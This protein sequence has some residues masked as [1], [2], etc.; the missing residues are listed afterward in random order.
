MI[1]YLI[2]M[3]TDVLHQDDADHVCRLISKNTVRRSSR[4][5]FVSN[6]FVILFNDD[7][8]ICIVKYKTDVVPLFVFTD[9]DSVGR[10]KKRLTEE[11]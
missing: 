11:K 2:K 9:E 7:Y 3:M 6:R 4:M 10:I 8:D 1:S 5:Y